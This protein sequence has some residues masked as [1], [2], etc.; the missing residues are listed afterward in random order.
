MSLGACA[1]ASS[2]GRATSIKVTFHLCQYEGEKQGNQ[3][4]LALPV[5]YEAWLSRPSASW[6]PP[7]E[8]LWAGLAVEL[9]IWCGA[10]WAHRLYEV[11][12]T[13]PSRELRRLL[14]CFT[15]VAMAMGALAFACKLQGLSRGFTGLYHPRRLRPRAARSNPFARKSCAR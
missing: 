10:A 13:G 4:S 6:A 8:T 15:L 12:I 7:L 9:V 11:D 3:R 1:S 2:G 14:R 5:A